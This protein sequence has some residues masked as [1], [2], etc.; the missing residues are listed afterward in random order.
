[1]LD[2][3][4]VRANPEAVRENIRKKIPGGKLP[5]VDEVLERDQKFRRQKTRCDNL[6]AQ[7]NTISK[8]I[9]GL[10]GKGLREEAE[11]AKAQVTAMAKEL[12]EL[13][14]LE[15]KLEAEIRE[16][17]MVIP[18]II[19]PSVPIGRDDSENVEVERALENQQFHP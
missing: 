18:N 5:L 4:F 6:R 16:R 8:Q 12:E 7:R 11:Q 17:M 14:E 15:T 9:G 1:M 3:K 10:M 13:E 19:D 2:I